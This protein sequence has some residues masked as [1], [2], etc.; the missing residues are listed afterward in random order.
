MEQGAKYKNIDT[1]HI[2][3]ALQPYKITVNPLHSNTASYDAIV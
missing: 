2:S 3:A 1:K